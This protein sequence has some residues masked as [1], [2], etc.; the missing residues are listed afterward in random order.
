[1]L[2]LKWSKDNAKVTKLNAISF[3]IP[4]YRS[5]NGFK[6]CPMAGAC[7]AVCYARQ[8]TYVFPAVKKAREFNLTM[9][10]GKDFVSNAVNDLNKLRYKYIRIHDSGDFYNQEYLDKWFEIAKQFPNKIFYAYTKSLHLNFSSKPSNFM[11]TQS[12][13][14]LL[15]AKID[16]TLPHSRIFSSHASRRRA[17]YGDG[18]VTD[19][20]A[21]KGA[22]KIG[23]TY[24]GTRN[25]TIAQGEYF[26]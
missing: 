8:G 1:M 6:T 16:T 13:G 11:I 15:D 23:L 26:K 19:T 18:N 17:G 14:G 7:A 22:T 20:L 9:S 3:G 24:H 25:L 2:N 10:F 12:I 5:A 4:A 21:I